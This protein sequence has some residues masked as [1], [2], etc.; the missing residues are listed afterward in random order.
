MTSKASYNFTP[1]LSNTDTVFY[2]LI[3]EKI[4]SVIIKCQIMRLILKFD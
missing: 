3:P 1:Y 2:P 4:K